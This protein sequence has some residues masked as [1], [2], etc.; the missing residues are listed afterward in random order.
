MSKRTCPHFLD[1]LAWMAG[2]YLVMM[3][4]FQVVAY[5]VCSKLVIASIANH[6]YLLKDANKQLFKQ[7]RQLAYN[8]QDGDDLDFVNAALEVKRK[9]QR[10]RFNTCHF[11]ID[12][13]FQTIAT[14]CCSGQ[15]KKQPFYKRQQVLKRCKEKITDELEL[16]TILTKIRDAHDMFNYLK[17]PQQELL[18]TYSKD[19]IIKIGKESKFFSDSEYETSSDDP[20]ET[21]DLEI[22]FE[23]CVSQEL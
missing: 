5:V 4:A 11:L 18:L 12:P 22:Q 1:F 15:C 19:R 10:V 2:F 16:S 3:F 6:L 14:L 9:H 8:E 23:D 7:A 17:T 21:E 20:L 13:F